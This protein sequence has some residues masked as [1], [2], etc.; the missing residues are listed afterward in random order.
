M[1]KKT[2]LFVIFL[3]TASCGYEAI[4][5]KK[6]KKD[7]NF[8]ISEIYFVGDRDVNIK[9]KQRLNNYVLNKKTKEFRLTIQSIIKK[10]VLV[11][12]AAGDPTNFETTLTIDTDVFVNNILRKKINIEK[13]F[14][15]N[16]NADKFA[17][18]NY[19]KS[20]QNNLAESISNELIFK[21]SNIK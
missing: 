6:N 14:K 11:K 18:A 1:L 16:N 20:L 2:I 9:I 8:S 19:E 3:F 4:Y 13:K 5:S 10:E 12:D 21:L 7:Y 15:Y 17:L